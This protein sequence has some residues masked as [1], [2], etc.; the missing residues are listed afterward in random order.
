MAMQMYFIAWKGEFSENNSRNL[1]QAVRAAG[2]FILMV[3]RNGPLVALPTMEAPKVE[4]HPLV[5]TMGP[6]ML[7]PRGLA[8]QRL[9]QIFAQ[10]L[11]KQLTII[12]DPG[13]VDPGP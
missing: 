6:V 11:S 8:A 13:G 7:S 10:N 1:Q 3:T 4:K 12:E 2:G 9:Q 5:Q